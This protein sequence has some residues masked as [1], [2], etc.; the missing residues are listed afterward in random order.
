MFS[1]VYELVTG[2]HFFLFKVAAEKI[3]G[4][5]VGKQK[6]TGNRG[7][8]SRKTKT[9]HGKLGRPVRHTIHFSR[10]IMVNSGFEVSAGLA[11]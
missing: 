1:I 6:L 8:Q 10:I 2:Y 3:E 7:W 5:N 11:A 9:S 4:G